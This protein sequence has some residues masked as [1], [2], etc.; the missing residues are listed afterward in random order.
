MTITTGSPPPPVSD[1]RD[2]GRAIHAAR[3]IPFDWIA[4]GVLGLQ[5]ILM[6]IWSAEQYSH[7][8]LTQDATTYIQAFYLLSHGNL[9]PFSTSLGYSFILDHFQ[10]TAWPLSLLDWLAP[11][12]LAVLWA[13][14]LFL[15]IAEVVAFL[16]MRDVVSRHA[17][18]MRPP[19]S[20]RIVLGI[21]LVILIADPWTYWAMAKDVHIEPFALV[22]VLLAAF[23]FQRGRTRRAWLWVLVMLLSGDVA[24]SYALGLGLSAVV[25][26]R[27]GDQRYRPRY[28][29][30]VALVVA[31][32]VV[33]GIIGISGGN[34]GS[35]LVTTYAFLAVGAGQAVPRHLGLFGFLKGVAKHPGNVVATL[36]RARVNVYANLAPS[37][38]VGFFTA[39]T[40]GVPAVVLL[41]NSLEKTVRFSF[42]SFQ[43]LPIYLFGTVG[44]VVVLVWLSSRFRIP[45]AIGILGLA[46]L[47]ANALGWFVT[48][49]PILPSTWIRVSNSASQTLSQALQQAPPST[50]V[51]VSQGVAGPFANRKFV[52]TVQNLRTVPVKER[53][54]EFVIAPSSGIETL[55]VDQSLGVIEQLAT[56]L[57]ARL[58]AH[59][60]D[61]WVFQWQPPA[62]VHSVRFQG[63]NSILPAWTFDTSAGRDVLSG[64]AWHVASNGKEGY[65][66]YGDYMSEPSGNYVARVTLSTATPLNVEVW[67]ATT[68]VLLARQTIENTTGPEVVQIPFSYTRRV[69]YPSNYQGVGPFQAHQESPPNR[70]DQLE[71]RVWTPA[72]GRS[73]VYTVG[74]TPHR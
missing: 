66:L 17:G 35:T 49:V 48:W 24:V 56:T 53:N 51:V 70:L 6:M 47:G 31:A 61:V 18:Q 45:R 50:E 71:V 28:R 74:L 16:W 60:G 26:A 21:G 40:F 72:G 12:G 1:R 55:S 9:D 69:A 54:V 59:G 20:T 4:L 37:G 13:Q 32:V 29:T 3:G 65:L 42:P 68:N 23:D 22:F 39:W 44:V 46:L 64:R 10:I 33:T 73:D 11:Q 62:G 19:F 27:W 14:D 57:G 30:G 8:A 52:Y 63:A 58:T 2:R 25:A 34:R 7:F 41:E 43:G 36:W 5:L 67:D 38:L 15:V